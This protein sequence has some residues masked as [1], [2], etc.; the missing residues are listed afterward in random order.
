MFLDAED[1]GVHCFVD[2]VGSDV[3]FGDEALAEA[4]PV[5][6]VDAESVHGPVF[7]DVV[8]AYFVGAFDTA[9]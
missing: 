8:P 2:G 4:D 9:S 5:V 3:A 7:F 6:A 1:A